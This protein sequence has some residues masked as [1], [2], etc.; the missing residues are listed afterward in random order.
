[1]RPSEEAGVPLLYRRGLPR[2]LASR[3]SRPS[4][5]KLLHHSHPVATTST[6]KCMYVVVH[7][8][9]ASS[10]GNPVRPFVQSFPSNPD[11]RIARVEMARDIDGVLVFSRIPL[12]L[13]VRRSPRCSEKLSRNCTD[14]DARTGKRCAASRRAPCVEYERNTST[15]SR[16]NFDA[17]FGS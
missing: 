8:P 14:H 1:M 9:G 4:N 6:Y 12:V 7:V 5:S 2:K 11:S 3:P 17:R 13:D 16:A 10:S 15:P